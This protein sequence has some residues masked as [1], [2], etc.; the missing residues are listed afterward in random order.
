MSTSTIIVKVEYDPPPIR[1]RAQDWCA[2]TEE[3][4]SARGRTPARALERL[5]EKLEAPE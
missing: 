5:A 1:S 3:G 4:V 2:Y